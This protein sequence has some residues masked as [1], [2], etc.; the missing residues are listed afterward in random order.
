M[1]VAFVSMSKLMEQIPK[2]V[3]VIIEGF[4]RSEITNGS[5]NCRK[6]QELAE[7]NWEQVSKSA[8]GNKKKELELVDCWI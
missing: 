3:I 5:S 8:E 1:A 2:I 6:E 7:G 4:R